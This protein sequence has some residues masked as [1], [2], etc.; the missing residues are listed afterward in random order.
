MRLQRELFAV[1]AIPVVVAIIVWAPAWGLLVLLAAAVLVAGDE[2]LGMAAASGL[3]CPRRL[4]LAMLA[5]VLAAAWL[6]GP[7]WLTAATTLTV[8]LL[9]SAQLM[10][11]EAPRGGLSGT[12]VACFTTLYL[13]LTCACLGWLRLWPEPALAVRL[14]LL[15]LFTIWVG[16]SGAY[17][18]GSRF[19]RRKMSPRISPNKTWEGLAGGVVA[20]FAGAAILNLV[21]GQPLEWLH[22]VAVAVILAVAAPLGDLVESLFK[23]DTGIKDSSA[24]IP[25]HGGLLDR[26]DSLLF[27]AP[28]VLAYLVVVQ[29]V[30]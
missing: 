15:Y 17:Y 26:T 6:G 29:V 10:R 9:P 24:L 28:P 14:V 3:D 11:P 4:P 22:L 16:D 27:A 30:S 19:G 25:G 7:V 8:V 23:R 18:V 5:V 2:L 13:G 12:A 20:T 21:L 1:V